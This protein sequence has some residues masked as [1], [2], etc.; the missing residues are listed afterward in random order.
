MISN[1]T[2]KIPKLFLI[3]ACSIS[4]IYLTM[5]LLSPSVQAQKT[6]ISASKKNNNKKLKT[7]RNK[8]PMIPEIL[9]PEWVTA[10]RILSPE[11]NYKHSDTLDLSLPQFACIPGSK[12]DSIIN[13]YISDLDIAMMNAPQSWRRNATD[14][15]VTY[16]TMLDEHPCGTYVG[17]RCLNGYHKGPINYHLAGGMEKDG[18]YFVFTHSIAAF[19]S[20]TERNIDIH[21]IYTQCS[22]TTKYISDFYFNAYPLFD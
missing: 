21:V 15:L 3:I 16:I 9:F 1:T 20:P 13:E 14:P 18:K 4:A 7:N 8:I 2:R 17:F 10:E 5:A 6:D 11:K 12:M 22:Y 19:L